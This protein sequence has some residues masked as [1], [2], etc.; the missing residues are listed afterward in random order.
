[1]FA[2]ILLSKFHG[3]SQSILYFAS[4]TVFER[5]EFEPFNLVLFAF[6]VHFLYSGHSFFPLEKFFELVEELC[7][8]YLNDYFFEVVNF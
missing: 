8:D 1:M 5:F 6:G 7:D 3:C 2:T 4:N